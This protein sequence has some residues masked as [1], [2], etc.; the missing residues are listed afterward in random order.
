MATNNVFDTI[1]RKAADQDKSYQWYQKQVKQ[2]VSAGKVRENQIM[3]SNSAFTSTLIPGNMY[4]FYY[5]PKHKE[6]LPYYDR[7][8]W[9]LPFNKTPDGFVGLNLH[10]LPYIMRFKILGYLSQY[11]TDDVMDEK[12]RIRVSWKILSSTTKLE[13]VKAC[14]K[15]YLTSHVES[16]FLKINY[17]DWVTAS[18]LPLERFE[19]VSKTRVW[20]DSIRAHGY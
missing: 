9:V 20:N 3:K 15:Q 12:T 13:P 6:T 1:R 17:S 18:Q 8:L 19:K 16:R 11:A 14:V 10:Y 7:L 2:L 4:L 5:D